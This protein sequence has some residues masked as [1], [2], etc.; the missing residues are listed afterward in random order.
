MNKCL[1]WLDIDQACYGIVISRGRRGGSWRR[2]GRTL[3]LFYITPTYI[4]ACRPIDLTWLSVCNITQKLNKT[5]S[6]IAGCA[7]DSGNIRLQYAYIGLYKWV[8]F[9]TCVEF[10]NCKGHNFLSLKR[11]ISLHVCWF[12]ITQKFYKTTSS[13]A[14]CAMVLAIYAI[15]IHWLLFDTCVEFFYRKGHK[16]FKFEK[17]LTMRNFY[18]LVVKGHLIESKVDEHQL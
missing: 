5:T 3:K 9:D 8:L 18:W 4:H 14:G 16:N 10:F 2:F 6:S 7:K 13:M 17:A 11:P 1:L 15:N 12:V